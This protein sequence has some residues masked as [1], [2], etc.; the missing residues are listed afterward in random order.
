MEQSEKPVRRTDKFRATLREDMTP[1]LTSELPLG[2][3]VHSLNY[4]QLVGMVNS[5]INDFNCAKDGVCLSLIMAARFMAIMEVLKTMESKRFRASIGTVRTNRQLYQNLKE[6]LG[7]VLYIYKK[8]KTNPSG[9]NW[10]VLNA[11]QAQYPAANLKHQFELMDRQLSHKN[12]FSFAAL[13]AKRKSK[14]A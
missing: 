3:A 14:N 1:L 11:Y 5:G 13:M 9:L 6:D 8:L 12:R 2:D 7:D 4:S 10:S